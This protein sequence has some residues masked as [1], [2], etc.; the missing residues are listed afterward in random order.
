MF[1]IILCFVCCVTSKLGWLFGWNQLESR[2]LS[3]TQQFSIVQLTDP[4]ETG[5]DLNKYY[6]Q[7]QGSKIICIWI[8]KLHLIADL[9]SNFLCLSI[10]G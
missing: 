6:S 4:F 8:A 3:V 7:A 9:L 5:A 1:C 2:L 10:S